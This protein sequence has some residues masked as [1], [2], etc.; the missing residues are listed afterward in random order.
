MPLFNEDRYAKAV[1]RYKAK[2]MRRG[3]FQQ[4]PVRNANAKGRRRDAGGRFFKSQAAQDAAAT[5]AAADASSAVC[6]W[7]MRNTIKTVNTTTITPIATPSN[8]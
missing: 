5:Q 4:Y 1:A 7:N 6:T 3:I 8:T 2:R